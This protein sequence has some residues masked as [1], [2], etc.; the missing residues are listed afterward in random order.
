MPEISRFLGII[1]RI[2]HN[3]HPPAHFHAQYGEFNAEISV[4]SLEVLKGELPRRVQSLVIEWAV[5]HRAELRQDW[6][7]ARTKQELFPIDPL[8]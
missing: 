8:T 3:E 7:R 5:L 2:Y 1:I 4:E 6:E